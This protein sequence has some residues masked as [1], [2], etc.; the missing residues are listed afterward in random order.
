[1]GGRCFWEEAGHACLFYPVQSICL[2]IF[3]RP[4]SPSFLP[5]SSLY[6]TPFLLYV[7]LSTFPLST[8]LYILSILAPVQCPGNLWLV[9]AID[10]NVKCPT[11][12]SINFTLQGPRELGR[13]VIIDCTYTSLFWPPSLLP[14]LSTSL[15]H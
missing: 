5:S 7:P 11:V 6:S 2:S 9:Q 13:E 4:F 10:C 14:Y 12:P 8:C 1:M 3:L 15:S